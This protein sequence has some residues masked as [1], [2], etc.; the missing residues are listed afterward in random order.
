M[1]RNAEQNERWAGFIARQEARLSEDWTP[2]EEA[3]RRQEV[4]DRDPETVLVVC[5][6]GAFRSKNT[7][8][9][10]RERGYKSANLGVYKKE[11]KAAD[12]SDFEAIIFLTKKVQE[13][14][15]AQHEVDEKVLLRVLNVT[16][17]PGLHDKRPG[18]EYLR[19][20]FDEEILE[21]LDGLGF[22]DRNK[23]E[24]TESIKEELVPTH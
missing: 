9:L 10:L 16:E 2:E 18:K 15:L 3:Q 19:D 17:H 21:K 1:P 24:A 5:Q 22:I 12:V 11:D 13:R 23:K 4:L 8:G 7:A 14:F 20:E 6:S